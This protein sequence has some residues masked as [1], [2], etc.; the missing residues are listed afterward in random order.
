MGPSPEALAL[1]RDLLRDMSPEE[2]SRLETDLAY[3]LMAAGREWLDGRGPGLLPSS[4][5]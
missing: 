3:H 5:G 2:A 1:A 4:D